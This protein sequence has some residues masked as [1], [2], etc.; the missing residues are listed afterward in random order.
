MNK[1]KKAFGLIETLIACAILIIIIGA[2]MSL[3]VL[4]TNNVSFTKQRATAYNLAQEGIEGVRQIRDTNLIDADSTTAWDTLVCKDTAPNLVRPSVGTNYKLSAGTFSQCYGTNKRLTLQPV[5][6]A[7]IEKINLSGIDFYRKI[8]FEQPGV[9]P[10]IT[11]ESVTEQN[12]IRATVTIS[13]STSGKNREVV[14]KE[15][16]TN[17]KSGL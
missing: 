8:T 14:L 12:A 6:V 15:L 3:N 13:W 16:L 5:T 10:A 7:D 11:S 17:W 1:Q 4:V 9:E 2:L